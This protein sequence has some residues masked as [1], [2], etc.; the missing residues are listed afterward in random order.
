MSAGSS[1]FGCLFSKCCLYVLGSGICD[2]QTVQTMDKALEAAAFWSAR[3]WP[4]KRWRLNGLERKRKCDELTHLP[5]CC[6][7]A[8]AV[9]SAAFCCDWIFCCPRAIFYTCFWDFCVNRKNVAFSF[10]WTFESKLDLFD[11]TSFP[12]RVAS[13]NEWNFTHLKVVFVG[14]RWK[15]SKFCKF[16]SICKVKFT[17][18]ICARELLKRALHLMLKTSARNFRN[19]SLNEI[20]WTNQQQSSRNS[21]SSDI[22]PAHFFL[23]LQVSRHVNLLYFL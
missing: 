11:G 1:N 10:Q 20:K 19:L 14:I 5:T 22:K 21:G 13:Q 18:E 9:F 15:I 4:W 2:L 6:F 23:V 16:M 7:F 3:E 12:A 17:P 8:F